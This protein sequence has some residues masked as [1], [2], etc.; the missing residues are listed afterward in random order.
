MKKLFSLGLSLLLSGFLF[1][2]DIAARLSSMESIVQ[3]RTD[4]SVT[5]RIKVMLRAKGETQRMIGRSATYFP[6]FEAYLKEYELPDDL[7]YITCLETELNPRTVSSSGATG[8]WQLMPDVQE[9]FGLRIDKELDERLDL[10]RATEAALKD[11]KRMYAKLG[12][13][14]LT[15]AGYNAGFGRLGAAMKR[16]RSD[17]WDKVKK[18]LPEQTQNYI[19]KF[20]AFSYIMKHYREHGFEAALPSLDMQCIAPVKVT[21][22]ISLSTVADITGLPLDDIK[23]L[24]L[25]LG[26]GY[27]PQLEQGVNVFVPR[28]VMYALQDYLA[29]SASTDNQAIVFKPQVVDENLPK[30]EDDPA[31]FKTSYYVSEGE[32]LQNVAELLNVNAYNIQLWNNLSSPYV[33]SGMELTIY[34]PRVVP[35]L[36]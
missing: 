13:W 17:D 20:I 5:N 7:K 22:Y 19:S 16:A 6:I 18:H 4:E 12:S 2:D 23:T 25:H 10:A 11:L 27:V 36:Q 31:Y 32:T 30:L 8:I 26:E 15:L 35:K 14:E 34:Q 1:A 29:L 33:A 28:R 21:R 3:V 9:E 24:N